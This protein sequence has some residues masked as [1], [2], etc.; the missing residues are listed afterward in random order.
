MKKLLIF[1][2]AVLAMFACTER[3]TP[4]NSSGDSSATSPTTI[5]GELTGVFSVSPTKKIHFS[6]GNLQYQKSTN[7]CQFAEH[8]YDRIGYTN[9]DVIMIESS[10]GWLDLFAWGT[11]MTPDL[12]NYKNSFANYGKDGE[13]ISGTNRD[14][15]VYNKIVNGG[16]E[17]GLWRTL[18]YQEWEYLFKGRTNASTLFGFGKVYSVEGIILL[19][20]GWVTPDGLPFNPSTEKGLDPTYYN[21][22]KDN[23]SHNSYTETEWKKMEAAG[24]VF[25]PST[26]WLSTSYTDAVYTKASNSINE[27]DGYYWSSSFAYELIFS[28]ADLKFFSYSTTAQWK[29]NVHQIAVRLVRDIE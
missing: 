19:P 8:Q 2:F 16:N 15:G 22:K 23:Y 26:G 13:D 1:A 20:D 17:A 28:N 25:L 24:A 27:Y 7:T 3:N 11:G 6:K 9:R 12:S 10:T 4:S 29:S 5:E 21:S 14:W 18:T